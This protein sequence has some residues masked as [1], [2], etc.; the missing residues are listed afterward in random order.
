M[1]SEAQGAVWMQL[2]QCGLLQAFCLKLC[3]CAD[4]TIT[5]VVSKP[6][7]Y[8]LA[9]PPAPGEI[10]AAPSAFPM[11]KVIWT[12]HSLILMHKLMLTLIFLLVDCVFL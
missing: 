9:F 8:C 5:S 1:L 6:W 12:N 2:S 11:G 10:A 3:F 7:L 4:M